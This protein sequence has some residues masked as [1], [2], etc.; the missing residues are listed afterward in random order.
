MTTRQRALAL[1]LL[2][3][4][5]AF[6]FIDR[7]MIALVAEK[8][9]AE[10][11]LSDTQI[12]LLGGTAFAVVHALASI[13]IARL[14]ENFSRARVTVG[15]LMLAS[16][17]TALAGAAGSFLH[18]L[19]CRI[20][21]AAGNAATEAPPHSIISDMYPPEKRASAISIFM[22]GVPTA[23][24]FGSFAGG[25]IAESF[26]W[27]NTFVVFGAGGALIAA[28]GFFLLKETERSHETEGD[29]ER[30]GT[31]QI[32]KAIASRRTL[33]MMTFG[34]AAV[35]LGSFGVNTFLPAFFTREFGFNAGEAGLAFGLISGVASLVGTL[36]GG[37][38][39]EWMAARWDQR[40]LLGF[41][42]L[43]A[44]VGTPLFIIGVLAQSAVAAVPLMLV[45]SVFFYT[46]MGPAIATLHGF[47][48][49]HSRAT[50]SA[51][52]LL[53]VYMIGQGV[54]PPLIGIVSDAASSSAY[55][56]G[57]FSLECAGAAA[58]VT[59]SACA[60]ASAAGLQFAIVAFAA[61]FVLAALLLFGAAQSGR[62]EEAIARA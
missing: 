56:S 10:F 19:L 57:N 34:V 55:G 24:L 32:F 50:G 13:P 3:S 9:K 61:F 7:V 23:A 5:N 62:R 52:F 30:L 2:A 54:G 35:S 17:S 43:G 28:L 42:A 29:A 49:P 26:G 12:G 14:A 4:I 59:G 6:G 58:Q 11:F 48:G 27:R 53:V 38:V 39:S 41:P 31:L 21:M 20:G 25:Q 45:G 33:V 18:L 15:F 40:W 8:I 46:S 16:T 51:I 47:L 44:L 36:L 22:L 60:A 1:L 37:Y